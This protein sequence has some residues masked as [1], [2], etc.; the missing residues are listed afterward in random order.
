MN[1]TSA[2]AHRIRLRH[3]VIAVCGC[4]VLMF[5]MVRPAFAQTPSGTI[6]VSFDNR[7]AS[8][9]Y[10]GTQVRTLNFYVKLSTAPN[11]NVTVTITNTNTDVSFSPSTLT[12][13]P[14]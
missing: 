2:I 4:A 7:F 1:D 14:S 13:T 6:D 9:L 12:F 11:A 5:L 8:I 10:F 3:L